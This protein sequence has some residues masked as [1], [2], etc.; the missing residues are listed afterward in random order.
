[1]GVQLYS[2][3]RFTFIQLRTTRIKLRVMSIGLTSI[4]VFSHCKNVRPRRQDQ[5]LEV[6]LQQ[7]KAHVPCS[8]SNHRSQ[9]QSHAIIMT[10]RPA[11]CTYRSL[12]LS[13][14]FNTIRYNAVI[15]IVDARLLKRHLKTKRSAPA[16]SRALHKSGILQRVV[17]S[18]SIR[19]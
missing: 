17:K 2:T 16:Y 9:E 1:M 8:S 19:F 10:Q 7:S 3:H 12:C 15:G 6:I 11:C 13:N 18:K 5:L 14:A 4:C